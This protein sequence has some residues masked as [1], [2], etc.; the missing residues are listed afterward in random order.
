M[1]QIVY[2]RARAWRGGEASDRRGRRPKADATEDAE[3]TEP[4]N[5]RP[6]GGAKRRRPGELNP[7]FWT[8]FMLPYL[9]IGPQLE[10]DILRHL[11]LFHN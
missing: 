2:T 6:G 3:G 1:A 7:L 5:A 9:S 10:S 8:V 4:R 11:N